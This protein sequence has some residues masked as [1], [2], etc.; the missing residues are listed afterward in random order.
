[1]YNAI[2]HTDIC[3]SFWEKKAVFIFRLLRPNTDGALVIALVGAT[4]RIYQFKIEDTTK[5]CKQLLPLQ[6]PALKNVI[7][8]V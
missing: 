8:A 6:Q 4:G 5:W 2:V 7:R 1:M 3:T